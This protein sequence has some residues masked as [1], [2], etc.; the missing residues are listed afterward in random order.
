MLQKV[1]TLHFLLI[2]YLF[3]KGCL[4]REGVKMVLMYLKNVYISS[5]GPR[6][7]IPKPKKYHLRLRTVHACSWGRSVKAFCTTN[8]QAIEPKAACPVIKLPFL[9]WIYLSESCLATCDFSRYLTL[10]F[11]FC[12]KEKTLG[13]QQNPVWVG[14]AD[15]SVMGCRRPGPIQNPSSHA[16]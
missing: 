9:L 14:A 13:Q 8:L 11:A 16:D 3:Q 7:F 1:I 6:I 12:R 2:S 5:V 15:S 4:K 10:P